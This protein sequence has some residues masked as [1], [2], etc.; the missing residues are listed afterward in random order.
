MW[1]L[2]EEGLLLLKPNFCFNVAF[3]ELFQTTTV[4]QH[5][6]LNFNQV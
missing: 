3:L 2:L 1:T 5:F 6:I 4:A